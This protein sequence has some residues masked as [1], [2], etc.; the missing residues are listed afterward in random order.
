M[1]VAVA[2]GTWGLH[3]Y[4]VRLADDLFLQMIF[5][6]KPLVFHVADVR[7]RHRCGSARR[8][9]PRPWSCRSSTIVAS[10]RATD[11]CDPSA[12]PP[13]PAPEHRSAPTLVLG[14]A[15]FRDHAGARAHAVVADHSAA[16][17]VH[18]RHDSRRRRHRQDV[19]LHVSLRRAAAALA[20]ERSRPQ[21][22]R[23]AARGQRATSASRCAASSRGPAAPTTTWRSALGG[24]VCYNPLH[25]DLDPYAVAYA[26][27]SLLNNLFGKSKEPFWQ[28]AYTDLLK[29]VILLRRLSDGYTTL[30]RGVPLRPGRRADRPRHPAAEGNARASRRKCSSC[31]STTT[32]QHCAQTPLDALV[33]RRA[34]TTWRTRTRPTWKRSSERAGVRTRCSRHKGTGW[35]ERRYQLDAVERWYLHGWSR[36]DARLRSSI[37]EGVVVFLS[38]FDDNPGDPP[39]VL[40]AASGLR[41][42]AGGRRARGRCRRSRICSRPGH[43]LA[44]NFPVGMNPG[45]ARALGRDVEARLPARRAPADSPDLGATRTASGATCSSSATSTTRSPP[46]AKPTRPVTSAP[47][48]CRARPG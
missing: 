41:R 33:R 47:S 2:V 15:A 27:A 4:P 37:T 6:R 12:L 31:R 42:S 18:R 13:Y 5:V 36:L 3:A 21:D 16:R 28:Q 38:L 9:S 10:R 11:A 30:V 17:A 44:L 8:S 43:V 1:T 23:P 25:N 22:R 45:L 29:F 34:R 32:A 40:P 48:R 46:S 19:G 20:R 14:E 7:L 35:A 26:I 39:H 24:D